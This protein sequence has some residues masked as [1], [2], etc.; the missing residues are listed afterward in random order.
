MTTRSAAKTAAD[1]GESA[2]SDPALGT[3]AMILRATRRGAVA[4]AVAVLD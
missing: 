3:P 1:R 4:I 2:C